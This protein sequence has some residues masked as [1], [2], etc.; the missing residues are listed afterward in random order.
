MKRKYEI[1]FLVNP[2]TSEEEI[3][4]INDSLTGIIKRAKGVVENVD[5]WGRRKL[6]Y[7][8]EK[9]NEAFYTFINTE[10]EGSVVSRIERRLKLS[11]KVM[12]FVIFRIDDKLK[13]ANR[14]TKKWKRKEKFTKKSE[15]V[16]NETSG[17]EGLMKEKEEKDAEK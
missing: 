16:R 12:R 10:I 13:K 2:E 4:K 14:L 6:A 5:E 7:P 3:K 17:D 8:I 11:E 1:G 15:E 9:H